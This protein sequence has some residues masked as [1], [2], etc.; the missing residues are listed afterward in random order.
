MYF[1]SLELYSRVALRA[2]YSQGGCMLK[3]VWIILG[4]FVLG[5]CNTLHQVLESEALNTSSIPRNNAQFDLIAQNITAA[6]VNAVLDSL[7]APPGTGTSVNAT[8]A[9]LRTYKA[10]SGNSVLTV[11]GLAIRIPDA[12]ANRPL[13]PPT[14]YPNDYCTSENYPQQWN[15]TPT[16]F[17]DQPQAATSGTPLIKHLRNGVVIAEYSQFGYGGSNGYPNM[18]DEPDP[19]A[20]AFH[21]SGYQNWK[22]G[23]IFEVYPAVY[24]GEDQQP[25]IGQGYIN[26]EDYEAGIFNTPKNIIIRGITVGG[27]R[28]VIKLNGIGT[29]NNT[30][31]QSAVYFDK[32]ENIIFENIDIDG[33]G[34][35]YAGK[36][37]I[38]VNGAKNLTLRN[39][40][41]HG[42]KG[43][44]ANGIFGTGNN[45][46]LLKLENIE[47]FDDGGA[48]G[49]EHNIYMNRSSLD[50]NF[51][52]SMRGSWSHDAYYG[53]LYKSRAQRN[54]LEGNYFMGTESTNGIQTENY[55]VDIPEGGT[56]LLRNNVLIKNAS[57]DGSNAMSVTFAMENQNNA[58]NNRILIENNTFVAFSKYYDTQ[59]HP[60]YPMQFYYPAIVPGSP[61][62]PN[63]PVTVRNNVFVGYCT[64]GNPMMDYRGTGALNLNFNQ[65]DLS[66]RLRTPQISNNFSTLSS[67]G[68]EHY[69]KRIARATL[70]KGARD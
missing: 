21:R 70:N 31:G 35:T 67:S 12:P 60:I 55:L 38:Y 33:S 41:I 69:K 54:I 40:R 14:N 46:G 39:L 19:A 2:G 17:A 50:P 42:F 6:E 52:V 43:V 36:A 61:G 3:Y 62:F 34:A 44:D 22:D 45:S 66:F 30:L 16:P 1:A 56:L 53:H 24:Q 65:V 20:G 32:S 57:G 51:T 15:W 18:Q 58:A 49:P 47:L 4:L 11:K 23:D 48:N 9:R 37:A 64:Y 63:F 7:E 26:G 68:Y 28:P 25:W 8:L 5:G 27:K 29:S 13:T 59:S 10:V